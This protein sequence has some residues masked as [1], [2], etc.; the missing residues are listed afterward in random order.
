MDL[1]LVA[2]I[3]DLVAYGILLFRL[4][5]RYVDWPRRTMTIW[6]MMMAATILLYMWIIFLHIE[7]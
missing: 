6:V 4:K 2:S 1:Y 5:D 7:S 3:L